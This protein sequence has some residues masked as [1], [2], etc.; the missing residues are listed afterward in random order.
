[1]GWHCLFGTFIVL[2]GGAVSRD[3]QAHLKRLS[4]GAPALAARLPAIDGPIEQRIR[5]FFPHFAGDYDYLTAVSQASGAPHIFATSP[6]FRFFP[7]GAHALAVWPIQE[8]R[9][10][11]VFCGHEWHRPPTG[12]SWVLIA[13][14]GWHRIWRWTAAWLTSPEPESCAFQTTRRTSAQRRIRRARR[15]GSTRTD[16]GERG[17]VTWEVSVSRSASDTMPTPVFSVHDPGAIDRRV[18]STALDDRLRLRISCGRQGLLRSGP[19][20]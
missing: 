6:I 15:S 9:D 8:I 10:R 16:F 1:M 19:T 14:R 18:T 20:R 3:A 7:K 4:G 11:D 17:Y 2:A 12:D 13:D 5:L